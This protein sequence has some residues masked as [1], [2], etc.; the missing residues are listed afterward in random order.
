VLA[1]NGETALH[2]AAALGH[3]RVLDVLANHPDVDKAR[4]ALPPPPVESP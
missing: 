4:Q 3:W 2:R 1:V